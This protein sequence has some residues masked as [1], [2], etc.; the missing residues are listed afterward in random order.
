MKKLL[1]ITASALLLAMVLYACSASKGSEQKSPGEIANPITGT[2]MLDSYKY[3]TSGAFIKPA[4][5][6]QHIKLIT[7]KMFMWSIHNP[8]TRTTVESA[9][10]AYVMNGDTCTEY[11][12]FGYRMDSYIGTK[13]AYIVKVD[14]DFMFISGK[15]A[16]GYIVEEV[17]KRIK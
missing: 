17:W 16:D 13:A 5:S 6:S 2:W 9:G 7:D 10:G 11:I 3:Q 15:L 8:A 4:Q 12:D 1:L 14:G